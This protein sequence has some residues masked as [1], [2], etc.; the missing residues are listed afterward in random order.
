M[1]SGQKF[2]RVGSKIR[3]TNPVRKDE[4]STFLL[5]KYEVHLGAWNSPEHG[6]YKK[7]HQKCRSSALQESTCVERISHTH[8]DSCPDL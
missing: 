6:S 4:L 3:W 2:S 8:L 7:P 5:S 1:G